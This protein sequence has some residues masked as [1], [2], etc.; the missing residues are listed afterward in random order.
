M[1]K[2][3]LEKQSFVR[4]MS[5]LRTSSYFCN[6]KLWVLS[7]LLTLFFACKTEPTKKEPNGL[8]KTE[9]PIAVQQLMENLEKHP[10]SIGLQL[11]LVDALD[12]LGAYQQASEHMDSLLKKDSLN[13]GLWYRKAALQEKTQDTSGA[14]QSYR[15]AIR[16]YPAPDAMLA[17]ANLLAEKKDSTCLLIC[18]EVAGYRMGREYSAHCNFISG[19][20]YART[21]NQQK[22]MI[23]FNN[24]LNNNFNYTEAYMEK[25]FLYYEDKK[26]N[27]A[28]L[29]F[30]TL[31][32]VKN[33]YAD[34]YYW[35]AKCEEALN[36]KSEAVNYYQKA[37]TLNPK[38]KESILALK[39]LGVNS[40]V[41]SR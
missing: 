1:T 15:Y 14:L 18:K 30:K 6:M 35:I 27:E 17:A 26:I 22:A 41:E 21:G 10:D 13:Y 12:N 36:N 31:V 23:A 19:V 5:S 11:R 7:L 29:V 34:G 38:L 32:T 16:I 9:M 28:L 37:L 24:C 40:L 33:T 2:I 39:R 4:K 8:Y 25:G 3:G 20:Y